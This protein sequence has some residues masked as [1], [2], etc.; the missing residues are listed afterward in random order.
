MAGTRSLAETGVAVAISLLAVFTSFDHDWIERAFGVDP[1][2]GNGLIEWALVL[3]PALIA[4]LCARAAYR[5]WSRSRS[6]D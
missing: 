3:V 2:S 4:V 5:K 6:A 1:D